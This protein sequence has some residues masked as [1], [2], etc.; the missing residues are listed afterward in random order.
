MSHLYVDPFLN[1]CI[2]V[3]L[4]FQNT[5]LFVGVKRFCVVLDLHQRGSLISR[6]LHKSV[7]QHTMKRAVA[8]TKKRGKTILFISSKSVHRCRCRFILI[9]RLDISIKLPRSGLLKFNFI[10]RCLIIFVGGAEMQS[11]SFEREA[12]PPPLP[13]D[14]IATSQREREREQ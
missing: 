9:C 6:L 12:G 13:T 1:W 2:Y 5:S 8:L 14:S 11:A 3:F 4:L 10:R 7:S